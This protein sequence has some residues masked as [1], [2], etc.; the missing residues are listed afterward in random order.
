MNGAGY[1][2]GEENG[3]GEVAEMRT[4]ITWHKSE[5]ALRR[6]SLIG[7]A[8]CGDVYCTAAM[9]SILLVSAVMARSKHYSHHTIH[10]FAFEQVLGCQGT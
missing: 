5:R 4:E 1:E 9:T 2:D 7:V 3:D 10:V 6:Q 8:S